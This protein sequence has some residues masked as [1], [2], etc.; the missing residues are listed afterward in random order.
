MGIGGMVDDATLF[1]MIM[2]ARR[3][4]SER[5]WVASCAV[6]LVITHYRPSLTHAGV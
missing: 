4:H 2:L 3:P 6:T 1:C 5:R